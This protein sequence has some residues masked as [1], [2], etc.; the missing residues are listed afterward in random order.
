MSKNS[1]LFKK[2]SPPLYIAVGVAFSFVALAVVSLFGA[3]VCNA[4]EDPARLVGM[5]SF[6]TLLV[7]AALSGFII[8][9][10]RGEGGAILSVLSAAGFVIVRIII[11]LFLSGTEL[12]DLLDCSCYLGTGAIFAM[13]G[14]RKSGRKRR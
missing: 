3:F 5:A 6:I 13:L 1:K 9:K 12:S 10:V 2:M 7:T 8:S 11:S 14:Q 4:T